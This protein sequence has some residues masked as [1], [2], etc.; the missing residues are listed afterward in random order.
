MQQER[1]RTMQAGGVDFTLM[2]L[3]GL[4]SSLHCVAM[5]GPVVAVASAPLTARDGAQGRPWGRLALWQAGYHAGRG[6]TYTS[7]GVVLA[8]A[9]TTLSGLFPA[10]LFGGVLQVALGAVLVLAAVVLVLRGKAVEA[11]RG[12]GRLTRLLRRM[13]TS[14][15][16]AGMLGLGLVTGFLPCGVLYAAFAR[17]VAAPTPAMG[18]LLM[19][20]FWLGTTPLLFAVGF[21][22]GSFFRVLGRHAA[23]LI[24]AVMLGTGGWLVYKGVRTLA[25]PAPACCHHD[26]QAFLPG[27]DAC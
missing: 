22:S 4:A 14:G 2:F 10:R 23:L 3:L 7:I 15:H 1:T 20:A 25:T 6:I 8:L 19:L 11:P 24:F 16:G 13:M 12:D 26:L 9:G 21:A 18:G 17:S 5:C 27:R